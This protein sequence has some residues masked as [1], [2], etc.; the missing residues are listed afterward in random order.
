MQ[1]VHPVHQAHWILALS[2]FSFL[3]TY[4]NFPRM[5]Q[6]NEIN[7]N[8]LSNKRTILSH[9]P[10]FHGNVRIMGVAE[11]KESQI[12]EDTSLPFVLALMS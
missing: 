8:E 7:M 5:K 6:E 4:I 1:Q 3:C 10:G 12:D 2:F 9:N 11:K